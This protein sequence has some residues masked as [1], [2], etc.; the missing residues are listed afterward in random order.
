LEGDLSGLSA[1]LWIAVFAIR[2]A[3]AE[4]WLAAI[5]NLAAR[6]LLCWSQ[7]FEP[8][9][10]DQ[11]AALLASLPS[12]PRLGYKPHAFAREC[13]RT[14]E[15]AYRAKTSMIEG[16]MRTSANGRQWLKTPIK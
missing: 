14:S 13:A 16:F 3:Q 5:P 4:T 6:A 7:R 12:A 8:A 15:H 10:G 2:D 11:A 1:S 9:L